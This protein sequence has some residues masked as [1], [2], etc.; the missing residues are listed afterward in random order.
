MFP[1]GSDC[2]QFLCELVERDRSGPE[3]TGERWRFQS[4]RMRWG[5]G[6]NNCLTLGANAEGLYM[7]VIL[8]WHPPLFIPWIE[9]TARDEK[10]WW[11]DAT[12]FTLGRETQ[13][14]L[15]VFKSVG[16]KLLAQRTGVQASFRTGF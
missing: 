12:V 16:D 13:I 1:R 6:Y 5:C 11:G 14:P 9:I 2:G 10:R 8:P 4:G 15:S 3:F 7:A